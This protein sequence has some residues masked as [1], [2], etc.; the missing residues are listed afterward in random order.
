MTQQLTLPGFPLHH[1][2]PSP[3]AAR[4]LRD[5]PDVP[6][7]VVCR[8][9][10]QLGAAGEAIFDAF[11]LMFGE[12]SAPVPESFHFD[13]IL[14]RRPVSLRVQ[15]KS[16]I[17]PSAQSY[18]VEPKKG[19]R[20]SPRGMRAYADDD[21]DMLAIVVLRESVIRFTTEKHRRFN[22]PLSAIPQL[23][24][25]PRRRFD[26]ALEGLQARADA[27]PDGE[28]FPSFS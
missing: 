3:T 15:I 6:F 26:E 7:E 17:M 13:R 9:A 20:G 27:D 8:H 23:R 28:A 5:W 24:R 11:M 18:S 25:Q 2:D 14:L 19:Y 12:I 22:I 10:K 1:A 4:E 16:V 21:Y